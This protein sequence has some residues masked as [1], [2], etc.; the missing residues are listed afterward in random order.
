MSQYLLPLTL[1]PV[2]SED[3]FFV[4]ACNREAYQWIMAWP[5]WPAHALML[6]G[7]EGCGKSHLARIW[8]ARAGETH[9]LIEDIETLRDEE[10]L[11]HRFNSSRENGR[12][13]L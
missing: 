7:P 11:L 13:L 10:A 6:Y 4:A 1:P 12:S 2:F 5:T 3:N 8:A 9:E